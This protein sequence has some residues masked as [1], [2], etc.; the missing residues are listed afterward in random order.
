MISLMVYCY[1]VPCSDIIT[2]PSSLPPF[3]VLD[4]YVLK[5]L[6]AAHRTPCQEICGSIIEAFIAAGALVRHGIMKVMGGGYTGG[7][8]LAMGE[9]SDGMYCIGNQSHK[10][11]DTDELSP[12]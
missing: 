1:F 9:S 12:S 10:A 6:S 3:P 2:E 8:S 5:L 11:L 4:S 7:D